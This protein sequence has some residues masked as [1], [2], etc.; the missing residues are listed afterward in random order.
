[1]N[2]H[3]LSKS[4]GKIMTGKMILPRMILPVMLSVCCSLAGAA[5]QIQK[6]Q[7]FGDSSPDNIVTKD[8][9]HALVDNAT[10]LPGAITEQTAKTNAADADWL[11]LSDSASSWALRK[12]AISTFWTSPSFTNAASTN[13]LEQLLTTQ[14]TN[15]VAAQFFL[16]AFSNQVWAQFTSTY[17]TNAVTNQFSSTTFSNVVNIVAAPLVA[18]FKS[19]PLNITD[20]VLINS[21]HGL[22]VVPTQV[23]CV[24]V[25]TTPDQGYVVGDEVDVQSVFAGT[26]P[27]LSFGVNS[28]NVFVVCKTGTVNTFSK[29]NSSPT[30]VNLT[31]AYWKVVVYAQ[32]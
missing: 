28:S 10:I 13:F 25:C 22:G 30:S 18:A 9:L 4:G 29:T 11:L 17:F 27:A 12:I 19:S 16:T 3:N 31:E 24:I 21:A 7:T 20:G 6:G 5:T 2:T 8:K 26:K 1:M 14:F 15:A 32:K 23:R